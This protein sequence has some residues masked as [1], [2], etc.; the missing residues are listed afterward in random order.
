MALMSQLITENATAAHDPDEYDRRYR[1]L[2]QR[3][4]Q[5]EQEHQKVSDQIADLTTRRVKQPQPVTT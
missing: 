2:E 4:Q 5:Q 1:E 3:Y